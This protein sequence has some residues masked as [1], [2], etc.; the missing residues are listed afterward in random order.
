MSGYEKV[1]LNTR[2]GMLFF[3]DSRWDQS[4]VRTR[5]RT[6]RRRVDEGGFDSKAALTVEPA[7]SRL[8]VAEG[9]SQKLQYQ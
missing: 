4:Q 3:I 7:A 2:Q 6:G 5:A 9:I 1:M 8:Q